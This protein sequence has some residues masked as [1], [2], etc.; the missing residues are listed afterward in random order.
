MMNWITAL[1]WFIFFV[2]SLPIVAQN[3]IGFRASASL[4][5]LLLGTEAEVLHLQENVDD[6]Q[7]IS[8]IKKNYQLIVPGFELK[9]QHLWWGDNIYNF[10]DPDWLIGGTP[11]STGWIQQNGMQLR[12]HNLLWAG[13]SHIP[14]WLLQQ[15]SSIT[16]DKAK[17]LMSDYIHTVV[18]RYR[19]KIS[20]WD[21]VNEAIDDVD[22][23]TH[24][25]NLR[26]SFWFRKLGPDFMKYAFI[27][28]HE[29]DP[30]VQLYY[31]DYNIEKLDLKANR[32]LELASWLRS[33]G[34]TIHGIGMQW[35]IDVSKYIHP[36]GEYYQNAQRFIDQGLDFMVTELDISIPMKDG[37]PV[38]PSDVEKQGLEYRSLLQYV[39]HFSPKC[40]AMLT[41]GFTDRYSWIPAAF[42][43][44]KGE[45]LPLDLDYQPKPAYLQMQEELARVLV[46]GVYRLSPQS[47]PDKCLGTSNQTTNSSVQLYSD[48]CNNANEKWNITWLADGTYR[49]S[50]VS[51]NNSALAAYNTTATV[52]EVQTSEWSGSFSEEWV[53][54]LEG[55]K[56][57]RVGPRDA[58]IRVLSVYGTTNIGIV[59]YS[60]SG[61]QNWILTKV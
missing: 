50:P 5:G 2:H 47:Q 48:E 54:S 28:A 41:W 13:D 40:R 52:G 19:G 3:P 30:D 17:S 9:P 22:N 34:V 44:T 24:P 15:E 32:T 39:L 59:D 6:G 61:N 16:P 45:A 33:Q 55:D 27:F 7:Y 56:T 4:R 11:N 18:S 43:Y 12:G 49:L 42:N 31:N 58:W 26:N 29:A 38:D 20:W 25:F 23:N 60:S 53:F 1:T 21:V 10:T 8:N 51:V 46:D 57:F 14:K 36:G 35:H 37:K